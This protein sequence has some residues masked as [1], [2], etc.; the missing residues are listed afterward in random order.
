MILLFERGFLGGG[1]RLTT[2]S[3]SLPHP[4]FKQDIVLI[5]LSMGRLFPIYREA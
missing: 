4:V 3:P 2:V 5:R 1:W